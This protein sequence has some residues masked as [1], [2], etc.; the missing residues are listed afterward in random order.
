MKKKGW[1][2]RKR[3]EKMIARKNW[4]WPGCREKGISCVLFLVGE[5][6]LV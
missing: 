4:I 2:K 6:D 3:R 1:N 5:C